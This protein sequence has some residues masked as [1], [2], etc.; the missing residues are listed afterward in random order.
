MFRRWRRRVLLFFLLVLCRKLEKKE[1]IKNYSFLNLL[2]SGDL[3]EAFFF[4][5][6]GKY[7]DNP[8]SLHSVFIDGGRGNFSPLLRKYSSS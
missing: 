6:W 7:A 4:T 3:S 1:K 5:T 2:R 8:P